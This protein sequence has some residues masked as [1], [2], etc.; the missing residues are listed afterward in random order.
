MKVNHLIVHEIVKNVRESG[1]KLVFSESTIPIDDKAENLVKELNTRYSNLKNT[2]ITYATFDYEEDRDFPKE[3][4]KYYKSKTKDDFIKFSIEAIKDLKTRIEGRAPAKGGYLV[5]AEFEDYGKFLGVYLIRNTTGM[6]FNKSDDGKY[7]E[8]NPT[9]HIDFEKIAM[10]C[11]LNY[12]RYEKKDGRYL[13]FID[14]KKEEVSKFFNEWISSKDQEDNI[15]DTKHLLYDILK[16]IEPPKDEEGNLIQTNIFLQEVQEFIKG[17]PNR[18]VELKTISAQFYQDEDVIP[19]Y[20]QENN[21]SINSQ[22]K[23]D[24]GILRK[25]VNV[26]VTAEKITLNFPPKYFRNKVRIGGDNADLVIIESEALV[27]KILHE[28]REDEQ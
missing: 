19:T 9:I 26:N 22:F 28:I 15:S 7:F 25:F 18:I 20:V 21:I 13:G 3:F 5:F 2:K 27:T 10:A 16:K 24:A 1:A 8:I 23:A 12:E 6:L 17:S 4:D 14:V 11:R